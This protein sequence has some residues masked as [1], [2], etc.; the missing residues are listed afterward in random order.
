MG[1]QIKAMPQE[2]IYLRSLDTKVPLEF[3]IRMK[4]DSVV[5]SPTHFRKNLPGE[6]S[7]IR[8]QQ[9]QHII[10]STSPILS[11][12]PSTP[13]RIQSSTSNHSYL[14]TLASKGSPSSPLRP[15]PCPKMRVCSPQPAPFSTSP[16]PSPG[17][18]S[19]AEA[20]PSH[21]RAS[22]GSCD[23]AAM[24]RKAFPNGLGLRT[25]GHSLGAELDDNIIEIDSDSSKSSPCPEPLT[26]GRSAGTSNN[27]AI[28]IDSNLDGDVKQV[29]HCCCME[30]PGTL[31]KFSFIKLQWP[32]DFYTIDI[33][34]CFTQA[35][36]AKEQG[37][38]IRSAFDDCFPDVP[39]R[40]PTYYENRQRWN[41]ASSTTW[42]KF[43]SL[44]RTQ[45]GLWKNFCA[46]A[47]SVY[48]GIKNARRKTPPLADKNP[49]SNKGLP[50]VTYDFKDKPSP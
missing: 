47:P 32:R 1:Y 12:S 49:H 18:T 19:P 11:P 44:G 2:K 7:S 29:H 5:A 50:E 45:D 15:K 42:E 10:F 3:D 6:R 21:S 43:T 8:Q 27:N 39:F 36:A 31:T 40:A 30:S 23:F 22:S 35:E 48:Q 34:A 28:V 38:T 26:A 13:K 9:H 33:V 37:G 41:T 14:P 17:S 20:S 25:L 46:E 16:V 24:E 4:E